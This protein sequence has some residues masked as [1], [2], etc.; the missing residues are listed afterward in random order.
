MNLATPRLRDSQT[1]CEP[2]PSNTKRASQLQV[3]WGSLLERPPNYCKEMQKVQ[4]MIPLGLYIAH[5][6]GSINT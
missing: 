1:N 3:A 2:R 4:D 5:S 6:L